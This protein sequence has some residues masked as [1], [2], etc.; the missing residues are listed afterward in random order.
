MHTYRLGFIGCGHMGFAIAKGICDAGKMK[1]QEIAV[2]DPS[3][4]V[5]QRCAAEGFTLAKD[6]QELCTDSETAVLA[7]TPQICDSVLE[8]IRT[9]PVHT[10]VSVVTGFSIAHI[11]SYFPDAFVVRTMPNTPLQE[12]C[13]ATALCASG[14]DHPDTF[15]YIKDLFSTIGITAELPEDQFDMLVGVHGSTPAY[16]YYFTQC[17]L[18]DI[19]ARGMDE[20][21]ARAFLVQ[22]LIGSGKL[23]ESDPEKPL[24]DFVDAVCSK[25]GTTIEA[26]TWFR[27]HGL[28]EL[29]KTANGKCID[30]AAQLKK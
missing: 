3:E 25:G 11:R 16:F 15:A 29:V 9:Y 6:L 27:E 20:K 22:T 2:Y 28:K 12:S 7:V 4:H 8:S 13:G 17:L 26:I 1:P 30:R 10:I 23:L 14:N 18:E 24:G 21:T 5:Q 19:T